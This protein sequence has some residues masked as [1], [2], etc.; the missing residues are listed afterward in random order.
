MPL[1]WPLRWVQPGSAEGPQGAGAKGQLSLQGKRG[2]GE[3]A[4]PFPSPPSPPSS[5]QQQVKRE[6][7]GC[8]QVSFRA[9]ALASQGRAQEGRRGG[10][11][12]GKWSAQSTTGCWTAEGR[13]I[14]QNILLRTLSVNRHIFNHFKCAALWHEVHA[15]C[16]ATITTIHLQ[17][18]LSSCTQTLYPLS[19]NSSFLSPPAPGTHQGCVYGFD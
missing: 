2:G 16:C 3:M 17:K 10:E 18:V 19:S 6:E 8:W 15:R 14:K 9:G 11:T 4:S 7:Q 12:T 5:S 1:P 13:D